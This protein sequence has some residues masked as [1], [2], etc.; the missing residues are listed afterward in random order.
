MWENI[1]LEKLENKRCIK[2]WNVDKF[3]TLIIL[4]VQ[5]NIIKSVKIYK[6]CEI[7]IKVRKVCF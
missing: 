4:R 6:K 1:N 2:L 7:Y 5:V 3:V